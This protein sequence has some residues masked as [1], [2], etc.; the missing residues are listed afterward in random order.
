MGGCGRGSGSG[1][2]GEADIDISYVSCVCTAVR[3]TL[4]RQPPSDSKMGQRWL[5]ISNQPVKLSPS[6]WKADR[7]RRGTGGVL[8]Y[9]A[10]R[11]STGSPLD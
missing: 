3:E 10:C 7:L 4:S 11:D 9:K 2:Q 5:V 6:L 1:P 8:E